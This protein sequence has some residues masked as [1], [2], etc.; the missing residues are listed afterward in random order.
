[1]PRLARNLLRWFDRNQRKLPWR[2]DRD[3]YRIWVSEVMLQQ[4]QAATVERFFGPFLKAFPN[5]AKLAAASEQAVLRRWEGLG[6]YRRAR[7]LH[8]A[9]RR[10]MTE[11]Q[12][13]IPR[14]PAAFAALPGIG[15]YLMGAVLSQAYDARLPILE[16]NSARVL[17]R[18]LGE[19]GEIQSGPIKR[20]LWQAAADLLP[21]R[22]V[23]DFNQALMELG[24]LV[25][26]PQRPRCPSCPIGSACIAR[27]QGTQERI[28][29][30]RASPA[31]RLVRELAIVIRRGPRILLVQ[32]GLHGR[33]AGMWEFPRV[34]LAKG[35]SIAKGAK[36]SAGLVGVKV[37]VGAKLRTVR[38][39]VTYHQITLNWVEA[40][41]QAGEFKPG[42]Y[43]RARW[44]LPEQIDRYALSR[45]QRQI[46]R[47]LVT[48]P[49]KPADKPMCPD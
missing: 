4:T 37:K 40:R 19:R 22:R 45:P 47:A 30:R 38:H 20:R 7:N 2:R 13:K 27:E 16:A 39:T 3:P 46:A 29:A 12:G 14:D 10:I 24:A 5:I 34:E 48:D 32:R 21:Q 9:A 8:Q 1:M 44:L 28:P 31:I 25:C 11:H 17:S 23:G 26:K 35:E 43:P 42:T 36:R 6:Y 41:H 49:G 33:W 18:L 15:G